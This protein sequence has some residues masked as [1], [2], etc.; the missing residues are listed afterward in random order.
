MQLDLKIIKYNFSLCS[1]G[2][3]RTYSHQA[4]VGAKAKR[5]KNKQKRLKN[6]QQISEKIF[7]FAWSEHSSRLTTYRLLLLLHVGGNDARPAHSWPWVVAII[8]DIKGPFIKR[9][10]CA[11]TLI[12]SS[13]FITMAHCDPTYVENYMYLKN[14]NK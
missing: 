2:A 4:K 10:V 6:K 8:R 3:F 14:M 7:A 9:Q 1:M 11:G 13:H 12:D 5:S